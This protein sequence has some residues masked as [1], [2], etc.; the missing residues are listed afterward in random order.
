MSVQFPVASSMYWDFLFMQIDFIYSVKIIIVR[1]YC[2]KYIFSLFG[3]LSYLRKSTFCICICNCVSWQLLNF[4]LG[5]GYIWRASLIKSLLHSHFTINQKFTFL[6]L[7][8]LKC[9][10]EVSFQILTIHL[11]LLIAFVLYHNV[12]RSKKYIGQNLVK[13]NKKNA[14]IFSNNCWNSFF[15]ICSDVHDVF[16][17]GAYSAK[18]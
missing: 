7:N 6:N 5:W 17:R 18:H 12:Q 9:N 14:N 2:I 1:V 13:C 16:S 4:F 8:Y 11:I 15:C 10:F 3:L